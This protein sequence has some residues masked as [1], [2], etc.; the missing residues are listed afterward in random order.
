MPPFAILIVLEQIAGGIELKLHL[1]GHFR[2]VEDAE[3]WPS[4]FFACSRS[5][6]PST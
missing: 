2:L 3:N 6:V 4:S 5:T 1:P